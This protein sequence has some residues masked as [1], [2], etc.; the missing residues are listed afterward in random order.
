MKRIFLFTVFVVSMLLGTISFS[1]AEEQVTYSKQYV[2]CRD[3]VYLSTA[4]RLQC[5]ENETNRL[6]GIVRDKVI[7]FKGIYSIPDN[8]KDV[9]IDH[10]NAWLSYERTCT[11]MELLHAQEIGGISL[12]TGILSEANDRVL[13]KANWFFDTMESIGMYYVDDPE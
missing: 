8:T 7:E 2:Q 3:N 11:K 1:Y 4:D 9:V 10:F 13:K 5:F 12:V 6:T